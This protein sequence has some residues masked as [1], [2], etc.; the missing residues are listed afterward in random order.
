LFRIEREGQPP[1]LHVIPH[2]LLETGLID[3]NLAATKPFDPR[4]IDV[5]AENMVADVGKAGAG[6]QTDVARS[7][8]GDIHMIAFP[9]W[10]ALWTARV[11]QGVA[12]ATVAGRTLWITA[13]GFTHCRCVRTMRGFNEI[14]MLRL[15]RRSHH[16]QHLVREPEAP[17]ARA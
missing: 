1:G 13:A 12:P 9:S 4:R 16:P 3:R 11:W 14:E 8:N 17:I 15:P 7:V 2:H 6:D 5:D 10:F